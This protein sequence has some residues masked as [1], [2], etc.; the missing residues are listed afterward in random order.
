MDV[1]VSWIVCPGH[2]KLVLLAAEEVM[3]FVIFTS[4]V[5]VVVQTPA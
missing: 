3:L 2:A 4:D 1:A 5:A